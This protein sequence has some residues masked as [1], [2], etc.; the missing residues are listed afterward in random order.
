MHRHWKEMYPTSPVSPAR[1]LGQK[2]NIFDHI[3]YKDSTDTWLTKS[4]VDNEICECY[5]LFSNVLDRRNDSRFLSI[6]V[7]SLSHHYQVG[8]NGVTR[9]GSF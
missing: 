9:T 8:N 5:N 6:V 7:V 1:L 2:R 3:G 4:D